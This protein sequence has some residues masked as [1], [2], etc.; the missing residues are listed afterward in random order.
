MSSSPNPLALLSD[1]YELAGE[2]GSGGMA[3]VFRATDLKH[4]RQVAI[5]VLRAE[6]GS[7]G[8]DRFLRE[9]RTTAALQ[10]PHI[11]P[12]LE[13]GQAG[14][15]IYFVMPLVEGET[16]RSRL[17]RERQLGIEDTVQLIREVA[18]A[19]QYAHD[20]GVIHRDIKPENILLS[21]GHAVVAD[22]GIAR[23]ANAAGDDRLTKTG[24]SIGTPAYMSPEQI[25][26]DEEL[27]HRADQYS[28]ACVAYEL[29]TGHPPFT[30]A[31]GASVL[32]RQLV[33]PVPSLITV[34]PDVPRGVADAIQQALAKSP[35]GRF[36]DVASFI[37]ALGGKAKGTTDLSIVVLPFANVSPEPDMEFFAD[38]LTDDV[39]MDL[40]KVRT[41]RVRG[42][43]GTP[44]PSVGTWAFGTCWRGRSVGWETPFG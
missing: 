30:G 1:R 18:D 12:L 32:A 43:A 31:T 17:I 33:D 41:L 13:S 27:D 26:G 37:A 2:L 44:P 21:R 42:P 6:L 38:G 4:G 24:V 3:T 28:L 29:L 8:A 34:R 39:I 23:A 19:L 40:C 11:L 15:Q 36:D 25:A 16:L 35:A 20:Q 5:K 22:F 7:F 10:H 9:I 14:S